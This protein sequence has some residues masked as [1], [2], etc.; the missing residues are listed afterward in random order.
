MS[1]PRPNISVVLCTRNRRDSLARCLDSLARAADRAGL[2]WELVLVDNGSS[3]G[4]AELVAARQ[5]AGDLPIGALAEARPG[6]ARARNRGIAAAQGAIIAFLD[7]DCLVPPDWLALLAGVFHTGTDIDA[8]GGR[9]D[10]H[11]PSD[12]PT[13]IRPFPDG[14]QVVDL[15]TAFVRMIGC[16]FAARAAALRRVGP[17]DERLS[18]GTPAGSAEDL[19]LFFRLLKRGCRLRYEPAVRLEHAHGRARAEQ[20]L[21]LYRNYLIGRGAFYA[22][23]LLRGEPAILRM[24]GREAL[25]LARGGLVA[26]AAAPSPPALS[27]WRQLGLLLLGGWLRLS[28]R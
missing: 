25:D 13:S 14:V 7:D 23:H 15:P 10:L 26:L 20:L 6:L 27:A 3:D 4:T 8:I 24:A 22:K 16:G 18:A 21:P 11:D 17:L 12:W 19:D 28:G 1:L 2:S 5:A 9:V